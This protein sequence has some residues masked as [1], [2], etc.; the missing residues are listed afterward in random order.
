MPTIEILGIYRPRITP[1][2]FREQDEAYGDEVETKK[3]FAGL[4]LIEVILEDIDEKFDFI[5]F[6]QTD[7]AGKS[8]DQVAYDEALLNSDGAELLK[9]GFLELTGRG[10]FRC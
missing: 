5:D 2:L 1:E 6:D 3:H 7:A 10:P 9:R 8:F 4:V